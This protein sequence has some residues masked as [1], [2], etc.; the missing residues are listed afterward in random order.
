MQFQHPVRIIKHVEQGPFLFANWSLMPATRFRL[1]QGGVVGLAGVFLGLYLLLAVAADLRGMAFL[2]GLIVSPF[3][4][5]I[6][7]RI[8]GDLKKLLLVVML[9]EIPISV[10]FNFKFDETVAR[11][12]AVSGF[13]IS[14]TTLCLIFLYAWWFAEIVTRRARPLPPGLFRMSLPLI[15]YLIVV[16]FSTLFSHIAMLAFFEINLLV[17]AIL[18]YFYIIHVIRTRQ[19]LLL[20]VTCLLLGLFLEGLIMIAARGIGHSLEFVLI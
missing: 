5:V 7:T 15:A 2:V 13:N 12:N 6:A 9:L 20:V 1:F 8:A 3:L 14:L 10:D 17:Q 16:I 19:D 11:I 4:L 18:I